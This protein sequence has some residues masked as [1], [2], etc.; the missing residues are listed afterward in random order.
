M[1]Y[2]FCALVLFFL[3]G[4]LAYGA[5][6]TPAPLF[7]KFTKSYDLK[8]KNNLTLRQKNKQGV[9][10][11]EEQ[12]VL[13]TEPDWWAGLNPKLTEGQKAQITEFNK[14][15][16]QRD[17]HSGV[18]GGP[19]YQQTQQ[20]ERLNNIKNDFMHS[21]LNDQVLNGWLVPTLRKAN[22]GIEN[23]EK[24]VK[25]L[26]EVGGDNKSNPNQAPPA[27][28]KVDPKDNTL[29]V[30]G[31]TPEKKDEGPVIDVG[32]RF[33]LLRQKG[34]GWFNCDLFQ[35]EAQV[36]MG[37]FRGF[38]YQVK[39]HKEVVLSDDP[40]M[41]FHVVRAALSSTREG[42]IGELNTKLTEH[43]NLNYANEFNTHNNSVIFN[44]GINF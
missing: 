41:P 39:I 5:A 13:A 25:K 32:T 24:G 14:I 1:L 40:A 6:P 10:L 18:T 12:V 11:A 34:R 2:R 33:D 42:Q 8:N 27:A 29:K 36:D 35:S 4:K 30:P 19:L 3:L 37:G 22:P 15:N 20:T 23:L 21:Y 44:Y 43:L 28:A 17:N 38:N 16:D 26:G 9:Q 31:T 7:L